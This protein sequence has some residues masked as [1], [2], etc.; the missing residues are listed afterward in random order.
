MPIHYFRYQ[1]IILLQKKSIEIANLCML[2]NLLYL[3]SSWSRNFTRY[4]AFAKAER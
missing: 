1:S 4:A 3:S 2:P